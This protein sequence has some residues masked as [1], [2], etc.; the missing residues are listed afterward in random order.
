MQILLPI[1]GS[2]C[3]Q[4]TLQWV[5]ELFKNRSDVE[6]HLLEVISVSPDTFTV[7]YDITD[8]NQAL[9]SAKDFLERLGCRVAMMNYVLG[10]VV[11]QIC[12]YAE[13]NHMDQVFMGSHGRTGLPK[14]LLG[15][16]SVAVM[17]RCKRPVTIYR[18]IEHATVR[19]ALPP[20]TIF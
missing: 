10:D 19:H 15:S 8:A 14:L 1:D 3:S 4:K 20:N 11:E 16:V 18:N 12:Q 9:Q 7:E 5:A 2:E 13:E 17:E 6:F